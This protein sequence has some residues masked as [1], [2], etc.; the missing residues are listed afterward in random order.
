M[1]GTKLLLLPLMLMLTGCQTMMGFGATEDPA[2]LAS[3]MTVERVCETFPAIR[4]SRHDTPD[5]I[6]QVRGHNAAHVE[7]C[8][9]ADE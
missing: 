7:L 1:H 8:G 3:R 5:T 4:W 6:T 2:E 9:G